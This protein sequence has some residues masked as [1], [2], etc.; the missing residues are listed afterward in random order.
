MQCTSL[1]S[2]FVSQLVDVYNYLLVL[3]RKQCTKRFPVT[4]RRQMKGVMRNLI[5]LECLIHVSMVSVV[6]WMHYVVTAS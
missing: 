6:L 2:C 4:P 1:T 3:Q 5:K